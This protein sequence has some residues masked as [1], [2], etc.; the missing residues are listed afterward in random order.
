MERNQLIAPCTNGIAEIQLDFAYCFHTL[1]VHCA[2]TILEHVD[3]LLTS[4]EIDSSM[5]AVRMTS[6]ISSKDCKALDNAVLCLITDTLNS[7]LEKQANNE[8]VSLVVHASEPLTAPLQDK[9]NT[10]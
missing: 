1:L 5:I 2:T 3:T 9:L 6:I 10:F 7:L 8:P 4:Q